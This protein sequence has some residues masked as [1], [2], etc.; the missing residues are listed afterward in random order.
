M[1]MEHE[2]RTAALRLAVTGFGEAWAC[3]DLATFDTTLSE[4]YTH[5]DAYGDFRDRAILAGLCRTWGQ[6]HWLREAFPATI[7]DAR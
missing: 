7:S 5:I 4:T 3:G 2:E 6:G 1:R